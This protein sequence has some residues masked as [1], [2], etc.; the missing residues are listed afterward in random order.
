M[1]KRKNKAGFR[2]GIVY[3]RWENVEMTYQPSQKSRGASNKSGVSESEIEDEQ[4]TS[5]KK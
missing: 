4:M 2:T 1:D 5:R 3:S